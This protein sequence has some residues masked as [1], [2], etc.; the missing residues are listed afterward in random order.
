MK[1]LLLKSVE[2][3]LVLLFLTS[4]AGTGYNYG[5]QGAALGAGL[6]AIIGQ[7]IGQNTDGTLIGAGSGLVLGY[8]FGNEADKYYMGNPRMISSSPYNPT[9]NQAH[10]VTEQYPIY[11]RSGQMQCSVTVQKKLVNG[12]WQVISSNKSCRGSTWEQIP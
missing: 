1:K 7:I 5:Q 9:H 6:G 2:S 11:D 10:V 4:C 12:Q 3:V 8:M